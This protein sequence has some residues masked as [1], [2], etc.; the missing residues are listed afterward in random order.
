[1][2]NRYRA[3]VRTGTGRVRAM[4]DANGWQLQ[5]LTPDARLDLR[6]VQCPMNYVQACL[7]LE[8][9]I[10]G[11]VLELLLSDGLPMANVPNSLQ[12][13]GHRLLKVEPLNGEP[14]FRLWVQKGTTP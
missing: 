1:M 4:C 7:R 13:D 11:Q 12:G 10:P 9:M 14:A 3:G 8:E 6:G 2:G 5:G